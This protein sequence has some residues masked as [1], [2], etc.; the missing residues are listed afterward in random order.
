MSVSNAGGSS[1]DGDEVKIGKMGVS[2]SYQDT[3]GNTV[4][5]TGATELELSFDRSSG[6]FKPLGGVA[7]TI[8][9]RLS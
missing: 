9:T 5:V 8:V 1:V 6:A 3:D 7:Q 4:N 2:V